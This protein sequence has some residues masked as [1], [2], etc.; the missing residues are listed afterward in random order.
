MNAEFIEKL[1]KKYLE[2]PVFNLEN[3]PG[4]EDYYDEKNS[5]KLKES[6]ENIDK[7]GY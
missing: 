5:E 3:T 6:I 4:A 7:Q 2:N 1:K